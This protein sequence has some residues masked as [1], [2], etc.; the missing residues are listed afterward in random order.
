MVEQHK[1]NGSVLLLINI[2]TFLK[3]CHVLIVHIE[4]LELLTTVDVMSF[5]TMQLILISKRICYLLFHHHHHYHHHHH[6]HQ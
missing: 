1:V 2:S 6:H 5:S 4:I 3:A